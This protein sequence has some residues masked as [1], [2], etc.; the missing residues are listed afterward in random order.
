MRGANSLWH[1]DGN[2]KLRLW[3]FYVHGCVDGFS[4]LIVYLGVSTNK[5]AS[6]VTGM[7]KLAIGEL[8]AP[9]QVRGDFGTENNGVEKLMQELRGVL[10]RPYIR[11]K[12][13]AL[14]Q[15]SVKL[16]GTHKPRSIR[17]L[18][19]IRIERM[20]RDVRKDCLEMFRQTFR[21]LEHAGLL[22]IDIRLH[23]VA[24]F[25]VYG[26]RI[27]QSLDRMRHAWNAHPLRG[28]KMKSPNVL[29]M[30]SREEAIRDNRWFDNPGDD[31]ETASDPLYGVDQPDGFMSHINDFEPD[32]V[33]DEIE[34]GIR[35]NTDE[36]IQHAQQALPDFDFD[37]EDN[38][39][40]ISVYA[41]AVFRM[42]T[43]YPAEA[44][45]ALQGGFV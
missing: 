20:W 22:N 4:R 15:H 32:T 26:G 30:M 45:E 44:A 11:G 9:S 29:F 2:E 16:I 40:G 8:G 38:N 42:A 14:H 23:R 35:I 1:H 31:L 43:V 18:H 21:Y 12:S 24:L 6:T 33:Q 39:W 13:V 19:N 10:H 5:K 28:K 17:S 27:Q 7:F 25:L 34:E 37:F 36:E 41:Q 3:G